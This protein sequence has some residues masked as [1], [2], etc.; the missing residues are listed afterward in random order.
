MAAMATIERIQAQATRRAQRMLLSLGDDV[1][2]ARLA[3]GV[4][5]KQIGR[6]A[7]MSG[8]SVSRVEA[9]KLNG[10]SVADAVRIAAAVGLDLSIRTY[11]AAHR[12]RDVA[13]ARRLAAFL[14]NVAPPLRYR[15]EVPLATL[16]DRP[17]QRA[18]DA[19]IFGRGEETNIEYEV[20]LHD[21]QAQLRRVG[22]K[23]RDGGG[24]RLLLVVADT[25]ANR[26]VLSEFDVLSDLPRLRTSAVLNALRRGEHPPAGLVL[27]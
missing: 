17:E 2:H 19:V 21:I 20:R 11:P 14:A 6:E 5:Q 3:S 23:Y 7:R 8:S 27:A 10:L 9:G 12:P 1:R 26:R 18:W 25:R 22:L 24:T 15:T 16:V 4:S 13:H